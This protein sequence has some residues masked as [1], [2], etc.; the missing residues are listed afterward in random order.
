MTQGVSI[1][2]Q[3]NLKASMACKNNN[4]ICISF[5]T[6][7]TSEGL[8]I[9]YVPHCPQQELRVGLYRTSRPVR[10]SGEFLKSGLSGNRN[11]SLQDRTFNS[12]LKIEKKSKKIKIQ[13]LTIL[14]RALPDITSGPE[15]R[16]ILEVRAVR[17][18]DVFL[19]RPD[20]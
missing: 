11:F 12:L 9:N 20:T 17:K 6:T 10:K 5:L 14:L 15:L 13:I 4:A 3:I 16:Q 19:T 7:I 1:V 8:M 18:T 2:Q